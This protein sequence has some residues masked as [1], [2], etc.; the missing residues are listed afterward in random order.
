MIN[1]LFKV[2]G[3]VVEPGLT[4]VCQIPKKGRHILGV[5]EECWLEYRLCLLL[6]L[7]LRPSWI[8]SCILELFAIMSSVCSIKM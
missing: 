1:N 2:T 3:S 6:L 7:L 4:E 8:D 5:R